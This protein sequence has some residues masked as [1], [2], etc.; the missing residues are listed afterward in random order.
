MP[1]LTAAGNLPT[2]PGYNFLGYY[3][4]QVAVGGTG[5]T[6]Y[7]TSTGASARNWD[8]NLG[9]TGVSVKSGSGATTQLGVTL[10]ARWSQKNYTVNF[11]ANGGTPAPAQKTN[12]NWHT[13]NI[14]SGVSDPTKAGYNFLGWT[15][16][17]GGSGTRYKAAD[18]PLYYKDLYAVDTTTTTTFYAQYELV[19]PSI[20]EPVLVEP[21]EIS[22]EYDGDAFGSAAVWEISHLGFVAGNSTGSQIKIE[23]EWYKDG[24]LW[25]GTGGSGTSA[26][27]N[28]N[29]LEL[30]LPSSVKNVADS[31][32]YQL[33]VRAVDGSGTTPTGWVYSDEIEVTIEK[34]EILTADVTIN[35]PILW[36]G[37]S[38]VSET[39]S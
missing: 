16:D 33:R 38:V 37:F 36:D 1:V 39:P 26:A 13:S 18:S 12:Q 24:E 20:V 3:D 5:G 14:L 31:G 21:G 19:V 9:D 34:L 32:T 6:Q 10:Y 23:Y 22:K 28:S 15:T 29:P 35:G 17:A 30:T 11:V 8:K 2:R 27:L 7:Y 4:T 25:L